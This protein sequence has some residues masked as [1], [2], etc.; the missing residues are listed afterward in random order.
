MVRAARLAT[1]AA[2][3]T[4][5]ACLPVML[6][7][8][9]GSCDAH[10]AGVAATPPCHHAQSTGARLGAAP[11]ACNHD[12]TASAGA[13]QDVS[14]VSYRTLGIVAVIATPHLPSAAHVVRVLSTHAPPGSS[15]PLHTGSLP[16]RV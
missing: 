6:D 13:V 15:G 3:V 4:M 2:L 11:T 8:C 1:T 12:H 9:S 5:L 10:Q 14:S 7:Q 16:L